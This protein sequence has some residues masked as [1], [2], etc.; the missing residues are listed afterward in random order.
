[1]LNCF[2]LGLI[3]HKSGSQLGA[4]CFLYPS[5]LRNRMAAITVLFTTIFGWLAQ[6]ASA[7]YSVDGAGRPCG[8]ILPTQA[9]AIIFLLICG[10][11]LHFL[12]TACLSRWRS[13]SSAS[14]ATPPHRYYD[15]GGLDPGE[16]LDRLLCRVVSSHG[17]L[18]RSHATDPDRFLDWLSDD[19]PRDLLTELLHFPLAERDCYVAGSGA[20]FMNYLFN[21]DATL[22]RPFATLF[23]HY[24][25]KRVRAKALAADPFLFARMSRAILHY[26][27]LWHWRQIILSIPPPS[28]IASRS[29]FTQAQLL[30]PAYRDL[31]YLLTKTA[32]DVPPIHPVWLFNRLPP[33][34][35]DRMR[36]L[37]SELGASFSAEYLSVILTA[38]VREYDHAATVHRVSHPPGVSPSSATNEMLLR[39]ALFP[40]G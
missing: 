26:D 29:A 2:T 6:S 9:I 15:P 27:W 11:F 39:S 7:V 3:R 38:A 30:Q 32:G 13:S 12:A 20:L 19:G 23:S 40:Y 31:L 36:R 10:A 33:L 34:E 18:R 37:K 1:M 14:T 28:T 25:D 5:R 8:C 4:S 35:Q 24:S 21:G 16:R 22:A 17:V